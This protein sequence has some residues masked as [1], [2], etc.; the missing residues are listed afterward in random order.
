MKIVGFDEDDVTL[1]GIAEGEIARHRGAGPVQVRLPV[2]EHPGAAVAGGQVEAVEDAIPYRVVT[3]DGG[4][5]Q[6][7]NGMKV[8]NLTAAEFAAK[9]KEDLA[10]VKK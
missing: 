6:T 3:K 4:P 10:S 9:L 2:G 1:D 8:V 7:V 5:E